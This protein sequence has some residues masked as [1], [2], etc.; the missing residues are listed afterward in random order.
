MRRASFGSIDIAAGVFALVAAALSV[1]ILM[2]I[3]G[4]IGPLNPDLPA[5]PAKDLLGRSLLHTFYGL[6]SFAMIALS[7][8]GLR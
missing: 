3:A 5:L 7:G 2:A 6:L 8:L 1:L 4:V